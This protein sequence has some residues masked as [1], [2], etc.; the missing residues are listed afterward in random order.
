[1][2]YDSPSVGKSVSGVVDVAAGFP[3]GGIVSNVADVTNPASTFGSPVVRTLAIAEASRVAS[4]LPTACATCGTRGSSAAQR[5][6]ATSEAIA[7]RRPR[8]CLDKTES[9]LARAVP[10]ATALFVGQS[11]YPSAEFLPTQYGPVNGPK[12]GYAHVIAQ[13]MDGSATMRGPCV[14]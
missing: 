2:A 8:V 3:F 7:R 4:M 5:V 14:R 12:G 9:P 10:A 6:P 1:M 13:A 11:V